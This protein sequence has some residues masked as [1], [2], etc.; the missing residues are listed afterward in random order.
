MPVP[1]QVL[2]TYFTDSLLP[3]C[4]GWGHE[5]V[6]TKGRLPQDGPLWHADDFELKAIKAHQIQ[7]KLFISPS[8]A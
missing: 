5:P 8:T 2:A 4:E 3:S 6:G 1:D 7:E